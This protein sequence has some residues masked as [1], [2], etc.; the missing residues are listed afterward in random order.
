MRLLKTSSDYVVNLQS[1]L[2]I[3]AA[4]N[5]V[6]LLIKCGHKYRIYGTFYLEELVDGLG[7]LNGKP[8]TIA[9]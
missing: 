3:G 9:V 2:K 7:Q 6:R 4:T 5:K 1:S 8:L